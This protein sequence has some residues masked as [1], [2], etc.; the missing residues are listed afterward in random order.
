MSDYETTES[1]K[2]DDDS[3]PEEWAEIH[4]QA[5]EEYER[6]WE[7]ERYNI[8]DAYAD[9][10]MRRGRQEDQWDALALKQRAGRPCHTINLLPKFIRQITGDMRKMRP[11]MKAVPVDSRGDPETAETLSGMFRYIE[12]RSYAKHVYTTANDS[13]VCCGIGHWQV[14][15]EYASST[16]FNQELRIA[17]IEDGV[18]VIWDADSIMPT[19]EDAMHCFVPVDMT[20]TAFKKRWPDATADGFDTRS[21]EAW[22]GWL[23]DDNI[24]VATYWKKEPI[25]RTL[26]L[27]RDGSIEDLTDQLKD[28]PPDQAKAGLQWLA[29][30]QKQGAS[31]SA[32]ATKSAAT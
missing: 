19:R 4:T 6:G 21:G 15:S 32:T 7:R 18:G 17:G 10:V 24:R 13:Q 5:L 25:K 9:L 2:A 20:K 23:S 1:D 29:Q 22:S 3:S 8:E 11:S 30:Q 16:T 12:N 27:M 31:R 26:A 14:M 28:V